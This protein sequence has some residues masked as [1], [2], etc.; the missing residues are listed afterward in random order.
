MGRLEAIWIKRARLG[1]MDGVARATLVAEFR[2][3]FAN[4]FVAAS[5]GFIDAVIPPR[6]TRAALVAALA[7]LRD[8]RDRNPPRKHGNI[9][10]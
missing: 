5:R 4:P 8:K 1:P 3:R 9:P 2:E 6:R 7:S 10:L